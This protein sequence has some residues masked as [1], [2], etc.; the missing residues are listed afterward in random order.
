LNRLQLEHIQKGD[1]H[2]QGATGL[3]AVSGFYVH[4]P[5]CSGKCDYCAFYS[6]PASAKEQTRFIQALIKDLKDQAQGIR[7]TTVYFGGGTPTLLSIAHWRT[8]L[9]ALK[10]FGLLGAKE[11]TV[12]CNPAT[13][14]LEKAR[15]LREYG[16]N[17]ISLGIQSFDPTLLDRLGRAHTVDQAHRAFSTLREAGFEN[18][19]VDL[20][21]GIPGQTL[22]V[23]EETIEQ[24]ISL[25]SEHISCYE[26]TYEEDTPL[27]RDLQAGNVSVDEDL[28]CA[29]YQQLVAQT[30]QAGM[31]QYEVSNFARNRQTGSEAIPGWACQHNINY[32][33][34]GTFL[35]LGPT[36]CSY[37]NGSRNR[38]VPTTES[39]CACLEKGESP[40]ASV[41]HLPP[42]AR[43]GEIAAFGLRMNFGWP[44]PE[45]RQTTGYDL[46]EH[47]QQ[48]V[49]QLKTRGWAI[50]END[51]LH[52]TSEGLRFAD[53]AAELFLVDETP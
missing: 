17:R 6:T 48:P 31:H 13:C 40:V 39:Y 32:W 33:R 37:L 47:W 50:L 41:D 23:W 49:D 20:M 16:V 1:F 9:D 28:A 15:L 44:L 14:S 3:S 19:N 2:V 34:G 53:A 5:F 43:A 8:L 26:V 12:E 22:S 36:A 42:R 35:G 25:K 38:N 10:R 21:F 11:W 24:A 18:I 27:Y 30:A 4:I 46:L 52:L 51:R 7:P 29:M 45:F